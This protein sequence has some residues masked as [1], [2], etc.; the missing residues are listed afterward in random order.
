MFTSKQ[1]AFTL[2]I[3]LVF[4]FA[5]NACTVS[6][7][8]RGAAVG[9]SRPYSWTKVTDSAA[10]AGA[11]NFPVFTVRD[12]MWAFHQDGNWLSTGG[13]SWTKSELPPSGLNSGY[14]KYLRFRDA[15]YAL[16]TMQG[17]YTNLHLTSRIARTSD[18]KHWEVLAEQSNLPAL[19]FYGVAVF[20]EKIWLLGGY[21]GKN[22]YNEVW[23]S[24]DGVH[25]NKVA[26]TTDWSPRTMS[27]TAVFK[28]KLWVIGGGVIDGA[29]VNN[30]NAAHEIWSSADGVSWTKTIRDDVP[31]WGG[32]P[33]VFDDKLW[34]V[35][36]N[37]NGGNFGQAVLV[38][39]DGIA[40]REEA[41]SWS[42]RGGVAAWVFDR[43]LYMTGGKYSVTENGQI[44]FIY[45]NDVWYMSKA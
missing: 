15:I 31:R 27:M 13:R 20:K 25:W 19:V 7:G 33:V 41:A 1:N 43:K 5:F 42:P 18:F 21:D 38:T 45:S 12:Q 14:Q 34:L 40:W 11:Y 2:T 10:F 6:R 30:V 9:A 4:C 44:K 26:D 16:G 36:A 24:G 29:P 23:N 37:R 39:D 17:D 28:D 35:G 8:A 3:T 32:T 22:Y